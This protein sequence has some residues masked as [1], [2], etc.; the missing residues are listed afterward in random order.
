MPDPSPAVTAALLII[1]N[2]ILS[3]RTQDTNLSHLARELN[4][5]GV[6]LREARVIPDVEAEI[7]DAINTLRQRYDYL[8]TT[9]G[10]GPTHDDITAEAVA[11]AVQ[12][13]LL[14]NPEARQRLEHHYRT[15][16]LELTAARLR[17]ARIPEGAML[18]DNPISS[19]PGFQVENVFVLAGVPKI[20]H[21]MLDHIKGQ[22]QGGAPV[23][24]RTLK[25]NLGEGVIAAGLE[26]IQRHY[27]QVDIGSY[28]RFGLSG[29]FQV[30]VVLRHTDADLL[31]EVGDA[32]A[33]LIQR[34][35]GEV[36]KT[37]IDDT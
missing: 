22:L 9:G 27:P 16:G 34:L 30:T 24:S 4:Q 14:E 17:M 1:G 32:V 20:M 12:R 25:C 37:L 11:R 8:F 31:I 2:E 26:E 13:P 10:I 23:R 5:V 33:A 35:G 19:A 7:V 18:I 3:G 21:A 15:A 29:S 6:Q 36:E 28:P